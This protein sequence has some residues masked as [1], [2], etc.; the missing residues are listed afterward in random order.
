[1]RRAF[2]LAMLASASLLSGCFNPGPHELPSD[3]M[4]YNRSLNKTLS[5]QLF[6]NVIRDHYHEPALYILVSNISSS[7]SY[8]A[9]SYGGISFGNFR[10]NF[11]KDATGGSI[12]GPSWSVSPSF[13]YSP[14]TNSKFMI[15]SLSPTNP[16]EIFYVIKTEGRF[17]DIFRMIVQRIGPYVNFA[18]T[19]KN[20]SEETNKRS[21]Q[22]FIKIT[23]ALDDIYEQ[24][25]HRLNLNN[26]P[27]ENSVKKS[28]HHSPYIISL[29]IPP[30]VKLTDDEWKTLQKIGISHSTRKVSFSNAINDPAHHIVRYS[31][32]SLLGLTDFL[33]QG[34]DR[35][36]TFKYRRYDQPILTNNLFHVHWSTSY[37]AGKAYLA[38]RYHGLW[39]YIDKKDSK[40][41]VMFR[42]YRIFNDITQAS[43]SKAQLLIQT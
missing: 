3:H 27:L 24:N 10:H 31:L 29:M 13:V 36:N 12:S 18:E 9:P 16:K 25:G 34:I 8:S 19:S 17:G 30:H 7:Y 26:I 11:W 35:T 15:E 20:E 41:K 32:R 37:P 21:I 4:D 42:L 22:T 6:L 40:S 39:F 23:Q 28:E 2:S 38:V 43:E 14:E 1:M 33:S 5:N